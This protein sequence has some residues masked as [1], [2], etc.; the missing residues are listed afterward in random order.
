[1]LEEMLLFHQQAEIGLGG[2][3]SCL[4]PVVRFRRRREGTVKSVLSERTMLRQAWTREEFDNLATVRKLL[5]ANLLQIK[6]LFQ[7]DQGGDDQR[8]E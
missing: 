5:G 6:G 4:G 7:S 1:M 2:G 3:E 8:G